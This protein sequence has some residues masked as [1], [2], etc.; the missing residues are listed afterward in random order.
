MSLISYRW[1]CQKCGFGWVRKVKDEPVICPRCRDKGAKSFLG[2]EKSEFYTVKE[3]ARYFGIK[4]QAV[5]DRLRPG[6]PPFPVPVYRFGNRIRFKR[7]DIIGMDNHDL[8]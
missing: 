4:T 1:K 3:F 6:S 8:R 7:E 2:E 5:Y